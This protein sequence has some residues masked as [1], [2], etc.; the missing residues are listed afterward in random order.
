MSGRE[1]EMLGIR[2]ESHGRKQDL[3]DT[4]HHSLGHCSTRVLQKKMTL[5]LLQHEQ[6]TGMRYAWG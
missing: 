4:I 1:N 5:P 6:D 3:A 2:K